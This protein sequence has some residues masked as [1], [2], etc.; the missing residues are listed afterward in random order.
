MR[1]SGFS[2]FIATIAKQKQTETVQYAVNIIC[3]KMDYSNLANAKGFSE[4]TGLFNSPTSS[5]AI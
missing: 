2:Y 4:K 5:R 1:N 3:Y